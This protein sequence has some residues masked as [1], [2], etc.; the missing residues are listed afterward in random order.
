MP[1]L[2]PSP[3]LARC[4]ALAASNRTAIVDDTGALGFA[5]LCVRAHRAAAV[6]GPLAGRRV[7]LLLGQDRDWVVAF[8]G[9]LLA[10]GVAVPL[11]PAYPPAELAWFADDAGADT[12]I[13]SAAEAERARELG[14]GRRVLAPTDLAKLEPA[15]PAQIPADA[16]ALILYTSG[17]TGR[18]KGAVITHHNL[19]VQAEL[20]AAAWGISPDDRLLHALPLHHMHG[21][22]ISLLSV[23]LAGGA[24]RMLPRFD[25]ERVVV[26]LERGPATLWMAVPTMYHRLREHTDEAR[27]ARAT[28]ALRL[29]TSGSAALPATLAEWWRRVTGA[30][31][32]ERFGMTEVGV[33]LSNPLAAAGRRVG[34]V[35]WPLPSVEIRLCNEN[36]VEVTRGPAELWV[37]GPSVFPHYHGRPEATA[38]AFTAGWFRTG[39]M[40]ERADDGAIRLLGRTSIDILKSGGEK[41]SALEIEEVLRGHCAV[42]EVAV[43]GLPDERWGDRVVA[44]VVARAAIDPKALREWVKERLAP[45]Q[46]PR[47]I[48]LVT[49]LPRNP[50]GKVVKPELVRL[51]KS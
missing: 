20:L 16:P 45:H 36:G 33:A 6:L 4:A 28:A 3:L 50:L 15:E 5:E 29:A 43:V 12:A 51:L 22:V 1:F 13:V 25:P 18:P 23:L 49:E 27:L 31:P 41:I 35:G 38:A 47:E 11:S 39:D 42:A 14:R 21:L 30:I 32:L 48:V 17:T 19:A 24:V 44:A 46:V 34:Y 40:A 8:L 2:A 10:G 7:A 37:R 9:T 26:E